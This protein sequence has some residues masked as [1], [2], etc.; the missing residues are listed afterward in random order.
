MDGYYDGVFPLSRNRTPSQ[1]LWKKPSRV[2]RKD[3]GTS[4][5]IWYETMSSPLDTFTFLIEASA[6]FSSVQVK[7]ELT[8]K[9]SSTDSYLNLVTG[10]ELPMSAAWVRLMV[11]GR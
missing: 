2:L 10:A 4:L 7:G 5:S 6:R 8:G 9:L 1:H 11:M 3:S